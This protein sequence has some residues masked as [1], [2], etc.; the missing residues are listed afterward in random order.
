MVSGCSKWS[1]IDQV[2][3]Q[4]WT[5][6][7]I[8]LGPN[9]G[10]RRAGDLSGGNLGGSG[11][12]RRFSRPHLPAPIPGLASQTLGSPQISLQQAIIVAAIVWQPLLGFTLRWRIT[13]TPKL[14]NLYHR[15]CNFFENSKVSCNNQESF[16]AEQTSSAKA[17][18]QNIGQKISCTF[19]KDERGNVI[20]ICSTH[21][22]AFLHQSRQHPGLLLLS[23]NL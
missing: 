16:R 7:Q 2:E 22:L 21:S 8:K 5:L 3:A 4:K 12:I 15:E 6:P 17:L 10:D 20:W 19:R 18:K 11:G 14:K 1:L 23:V 9:P 13:S